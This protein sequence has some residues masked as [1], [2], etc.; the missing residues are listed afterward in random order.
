MGTVCLVWNLTR[1]KIN[2][3]IVN[4][5]DKIRTEQNDSL[6]R[7][8]SDTDVITEL[9]KIVWVNELLD[10]VNNELIVAKSEK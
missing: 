7:I 1:E 6:K 5:V 9:I 10:D 3:N 8:K 2:Q 4:I